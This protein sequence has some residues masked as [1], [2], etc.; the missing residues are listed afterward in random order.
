MQKSSA[1]GGSVGV[2]VFGY[3]RGEFGLGESARQY[4]RAL[5]AAG[6]DVALVDMDLGLPHGWKD[7]SLEAL[8]GTSAPFAVNLVFVNPDYLDTALE[9]IGSDSLAGSHLIACWFWELDRVPDAWLSSLDKVDELLVSSRFVEDAF[10]KVTDKP[11]LRVPLPLA[12]LSDSGLERADF[13]LPEGR[14]IFLASFDFNSWIARKNPYAVVEAFLQAFSATTEP[15]LLVLKTSNGFRYP[16]QL[17]ALLA[18]TVADPRIVVRDDIIERAHM[19]ALHRC[20]DAY[21]SLHRAEGFGLGLAEAMALGKPVIATNWS[22]NLDFMSSDVACMVDYQRVA[23]K[24]GEYPHFEGATWAEPDVASAAAAMY[25]LAQDPSGA[26]RLGARAREHVLKELAPEK[27]ASAIRRRLQEL[28]S[29]QRAG[30]E[31]R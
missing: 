27:A 31:D 3:L 29:V 10:R 22:G 4:A 16:T 9:R 18:V 20:C 11:I 25:R 2:N 13:D 7:D 28:H 14:F 8:L 21:V 19:T 30:G 23:V 6:V 12:Q 24:P 1:E 26:A 17:R 15:V 5:M